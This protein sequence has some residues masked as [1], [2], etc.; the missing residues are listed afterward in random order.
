MRVWIYG[1]L[2]NDDDIQMDSLENQME[3]GRCYA[4][5]HGYSIIGESFDDN[6]S[7]MRFDR[8]GLNQ[9][10]Q[11][12]DAEKI[13]AVIVKDLSRLGRHKIQ[14]ALYIDYLRQ[15]DIAVLSVTEGLNTLVDEDEL[16]VGIRGLMNDFYARDIGNKIR[17]GYREKQKAGIVVTPPFGYWKDRNTGCV[18]QHP[19][20]AE[21]VRLIFEMYLQGCGQKDIAR[22]LNRLGRKTPAQLRAERYG[23]ELYSSRKSKTGQF[24]WSYV[25]VK[26]VL[27]EEG[28]TGVLINHRTET[29]CGKVKRIDQDCWI[30]HEDFYPAIITKEEWRQTQE[31]LKQNARPANG[32]RAAHR[33]A[34]L[35]TCGDCGNPFV[36]M[37]RYWNGN[38]RVEYVCKGY[39]GHGKEFCSSH[40]IHEETIEAQV[41]EYA[42][43]L[44]ECWQTEQ[45]ELRR[46]HKLWSL[47]QPMIEARIAE[48]REE[49]RQDEEDIDEL[50]MLKIQ[51]GK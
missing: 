20:A 15:R 7:G 36:P 42:E 10:T 33:Y 4:D 8:E 9:V 34:G 16:M 43:L 47:R 17:Q 51:R 25:S 40:R 30:R 6:V 44:R 13:D 27:V 24:V 37:V 38:R 35:L 50:L 32:N 1:R 3:I 41:M 14:T 22:R 49:I 2:S 18:Y 21:T 28:Y 11:A 46:L 29:H 31:L 19:D 39:H 26:N 12:A 5:S 48:L 45:A 23:E